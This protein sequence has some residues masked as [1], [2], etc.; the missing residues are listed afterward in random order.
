[1]NQA[2]SKVAGECRLCGGQNG[3]HAPWC[4]KGH[5]ADEPRT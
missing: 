1:M 5:H 4:G 2:S 3:Q